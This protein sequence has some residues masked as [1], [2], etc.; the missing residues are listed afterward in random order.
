MENEQNMG[1]LNLHSDAPVVVNSHRQVVQ[2]HVHPVVVI[3][4]VLQLLHISLM[5]RKPRHT[6]NR[7]V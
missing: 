6:G 7:K 3:Y 2:L 1:R 4:Q 5:P